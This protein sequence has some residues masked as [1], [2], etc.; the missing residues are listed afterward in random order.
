[1]IRARVL[2]PAGM[3][4]TDYCADGLPHAAAGYRFEA[5]AVKPAAP[6][7]MAQPFA[8]GALCST[9]GDLLAWQRALEAGAVIRRDTLARM[10][11]PYTLRNGTTSAYG[12]GVIIGNFSGHVR[13]SH[14][15]DI[16]GFASALS[17][18]PDDDV[19]VILLSNVESRAASQLTTKISRIVLGLPEPS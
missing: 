3:T 19:T 2:I 15:G 7:D 11:T 6:L 18:Y 16:H 14:T 12:Y 17:R 9:V 1:V 5:G 4:A 10:R 13:I 8:A